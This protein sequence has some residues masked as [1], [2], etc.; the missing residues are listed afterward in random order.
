MSSIHH[1]LL[2]IG[3]NFKNANIIV[4]NV[5]IKKDLYGKIILYE[6][7]DN[8][9]KT[10][11]DF[12]IQS[13][14]TLLFVF[15]I[16]ANVFCIAVFG[17]ILTLSMQTKNFETKNRYFNGLLIFQICYF[18]FDILWAFGYFQIIPMENGGLTVVRYAKMCYFIFG[19]FAAFCWFM[20][21]EILMGAKFSRK[22][23]NRL[24]IG[25]P[26]LISTATT[27]IISIIT[28]TDKMIK[29]PLVSISLM[30]IPGIYTVFAGIYSLYMSIKS[31]TIVQKRR[32]ISLGLFPFGLI[33]FTLVQIYLLEIPIFC[34]GTTFILF[35]LFVSKI[36]S[37]VSTDAL[38]GINNRSAL[39]KYIGEYTEF[40]C[41]Y[42]LMIDVDKFKLIND[43][44]G[45]VE[46]DRA[47]VLLAQ[48]LKRGTEMSDNRSFL[49]R[50]GGDEFIIITSNEN[51]FDI[52][53]YVENLHKAVSETK[54]KTKVYEIKVSIG[55]C[56]VHEN[57][58]ILSVI[59]NADERM[60]KI[61]AEKKKNEIK[62]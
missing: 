33:L 34:L 46:G 14:E 55:Y 35:L 44:F 40:N 6:R 45:H 22:K 32:Y 11:V 23:K 52:D 61:K 41:T 26:I 3:V 57:D 27:I 15:F 5:Y 36:Q 43:N 39:T 25:I 38:T 10:W 62:Q 9:D 48:A 58:S 18:L 56:Q 2:K 12:M 60:Y 17:V 42:V 8:M 59:E 13:N 20:Y 30:F 1:T 37:Q 54:S 29:N 19:G 47:L 50:Y 7:G 31:S 4:E 16:L 21:I 49:A 28:D 53:K 24:I 51:E